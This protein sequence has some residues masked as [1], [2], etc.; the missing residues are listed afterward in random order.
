MTT[1]VSRID[2]T[3]PSRTTEATII[4]PRSR[5]LGSD[6]EAGDGVFKEGSEFI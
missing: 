5:A 6:G 1:V 4:V 2:I 3:A